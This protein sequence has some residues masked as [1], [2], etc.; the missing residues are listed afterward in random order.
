[1]SRI[2][3]DNAQPLVMIRFQNLMGA[4]VM[5]YATDLGHRTDYRWRCWGCFLT[6]DGHNLAVNRDRANEHA[7]AC[8]ALPQPQRPAKTDA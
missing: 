5:V 7:T 6:G 3:K 1:V 8:R 4:L 2:D